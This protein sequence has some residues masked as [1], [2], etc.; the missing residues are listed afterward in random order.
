MQITSQ[1][2]SP[3]L[4][5]I[6]HRST[7]TR[8]VASRG[9]RQHAWWHSS[10]KTRQ[11]IKSGRY[12]VPAPT[13]LRRVKRALD[14]EHR[15][16]PHQ[17]YLAVASRH[18]EDGGVARSALVPRRDVLGCTSWLLWQGKAAPEAL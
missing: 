16:M 9:Y 6:A 5:G 18:V 7:C 1:C 15:L 17:S 14:L 2:N 13:T 12:Q 3:D 8:N 11:A 10:Q 4:G